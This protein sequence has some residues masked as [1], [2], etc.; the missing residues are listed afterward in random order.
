MPKV[1]YYHEFPINQHTYI[2]GATAE[3]L[4]F[5]GSEDGDVSELQKFYQDELIDDKQAVNDYAIQ[6]AEYLN[7]QRQAFTLPIDISG[8]A[9]QEKVWRQVVE[10][11]YGKTTNY[12]KIAAAI[13]RPKAVRAVGTAIGKN[14]ILMVIPCHRVLTKDNDLGGYRGGLDMKRSLLKLEGSL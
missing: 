9:F 14:P 3:G 5:V 10:I 8:T 11:P 7:K 2:I 12:T 6:I 4:A 1:I 13:G